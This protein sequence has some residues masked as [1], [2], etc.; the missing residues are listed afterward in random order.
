MSGILFS[1]FASCEPLSLKPQKDHHLS[2]LLI[3]KLTNLVYT[4][5][6]FITRLPKCTDAI[7][8]LLIPMILVLED[9]YDPLLYIDAKKVAV[10]FHLRLLSLSL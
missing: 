6:T 7:T 10:A 2:Q 5:D 9:R 8:K 3:M 4:E 1:I